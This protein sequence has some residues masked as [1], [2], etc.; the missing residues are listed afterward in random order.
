[1]ITNR[2]EDTRP[3]LIDEHHKI[4]WLPDA[5]ANSFGAWLEN[6]RDNSISKQR[7][8]GTPVP[9][10]RNE[11]DPSD[12]VVVGS[13]KELVELAK[14]DKAPEDIHIPTVDNIV[15]KL[16]SKKDGK[17]HNYVRVPDVLD[18]WVDAGTASFNVLRYPAQQ[19][20]EFLKEW[21]PMAF[22][23]G[24]FLPT[25]TCAFSR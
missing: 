22:I 4:N 12:Y 19:S 17:E 10:W 8:W 7:Y 9:I 13:V 14:L 15:L 18:V 2:V 25:S 1:L 16:I 11:D 6:L 23:L 20:E 3:K 24:T 21:F 5:A